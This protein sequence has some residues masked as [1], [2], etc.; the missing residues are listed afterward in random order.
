VQDFE[1]HGRGVDDE[2]QKQDALCRFSNRLLLVNEEAHLS[3]EVSELVGLRLG[4]FV[5]QVEGQRV[6]QVGEYVD[7]ESPGSV[8]DGPYYFG[9]NSGRLGTPHQKSTELITDSAPIETEEVS[10]RD[11]HQYV[12]KALHEV[13]RGKPCPTWDEGRICWR[14]SSLK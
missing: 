2:A 1:C 6:I 8:N 12:V 7:T 9:E 5:R 4:N 10:L 13:P 14:V 11:V 3:Q